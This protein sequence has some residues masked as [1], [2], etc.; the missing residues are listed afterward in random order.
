MINFDILIE[1][2]SFET[3]GMS[4]HAH[5]LSPSNNGLFS[6][7]I[8]QSGSI[9]FVSYGYESG[10]EKYFAENALEALGCPTSM[11]K[12]SLECLQAASPEDV[13]KKIT[14]SNEDAFNLEK[15]VKF[16]FLP[17]VDSYAVNPFLPIDPL[18]AMKTGMFNRI[19]YFVYDGLF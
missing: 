9:L 19:R 4:V 7:A 3:G 15:P 2:L 1:I 10:K 11:D 6:G 8:A 14:D 16:S 17:V 12:R 13:T 5:V 18:E